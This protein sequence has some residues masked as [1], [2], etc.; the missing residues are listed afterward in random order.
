MKCQ[1]FQKSRAVPGRTL[2]QAN[3]PAQRPVGRDNNA[4]R[5]AA[6]WVPLSLRRLSILS[7]QFILKITEVLYSAFITFPQCI[8]ILSAKEQIRSIS[9]ENSEV[10]KLN[11]HQD[12]DFEI[13]SRLTHM[14]L[15]YFA[16]IDDKQLSLDLCK[17][18]FSETG[19]IKRP[20]GPVK[21]GPS[22]I[23]ESQEES[24]KRF[25]AT[26]HIVTNML[27]KKTDM[28]WK[29]RANLQAMHMWA[30]E[31]QESTAL[32]SYFLAHSVLEANFIKE[33]SD[34]K[35][36]ELAVRVVWRSGS[37]MMAML[38]TGEEN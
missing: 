27:F 10:P 26:Q 22:A 2:G 7:T 9:N 19:S 8:D 38:K 20:R 16:A 11:T 28:G 17:S 37:G 14:V 15:T 24:F 36:S 1:A 4:S 12:F 31:M 3:T 18:L 6:G 35:I 23:Y 33:D 13:Q 21:S 32:E 5:W 25:R 34:W 29:L 30:P